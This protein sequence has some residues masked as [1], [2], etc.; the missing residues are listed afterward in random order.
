M[1]FFLIAPILFNATWIIDTF[2]SRLFKKEQN[3]WVL[4]SSI[5]TLM[6]IGGIIAL[7]VALMILPFSYNQILSVPINTILIIIWCGIIYG[8]AAYPYF[9]A[10]NHENIE[11]IVPILQ[12]IPL[13]SYIFGVIVLWESIWSLHILLMVCIIVVTWLFSRNF[14]ENRINRKWMIRTLCSACLYG[15]FYV[16][17]KYWGGESISIRSAFFWEHIGVAIW[18]LSFAIPSKA[19][20]TTIKYLQANGWKFT[21]LNIINEL[22]FI[23]GIMIINYLTL[24]HPVAVINTLTSWIQPIIGFVMVFI[25]HKLIPKVYERDYTTK[26]I[27]YKIILCILSLVLLWRFFHII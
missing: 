11:N 21:I 2:L 19:R 23:I 13:F 17:F 18:C 8:I 6:I 27:V 15:L 4:E 5:S 25:A 20:R 16:L 22:I 12:T 9:H 10:L 26:T 7:L 1:L 14:K 24:S 3:N